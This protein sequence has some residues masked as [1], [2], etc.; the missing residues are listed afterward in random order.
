VILGEQFKLF[1]HAEFIKCSERTADDA[2]C[3]VVAETLADDAGAKATVGIVVSKI[4]ISMLLKARPLVLIQNPF[5][6]RFSILSREGG[7]ILPQW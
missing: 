6:E 1:R 5:C 3:E 4:D 2:E 7:G